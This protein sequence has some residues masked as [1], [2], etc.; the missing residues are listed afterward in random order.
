MFSGALILV[1]NLVVV[2][3]IAE[4]LAPEAPLA[5][6]LSIWLTALYYPLIYWT[7]RGMEVGLVTLTVSMS[8]LLAL[9]L[10]DRVRRQD[11]AALAALMVAG[12]LTRPDVVVPCAVIADLSADRCPCSRRVVAIVLLGA[13]VG[14]LTTPPSDDT[15]PL[16]NT[17]YLVQRCARRPFVSGPDR[18]AVFDLLHLIVL[19]VL[20]AVAWSLARRAGAATAPNLLAALFAV[21]CA[22][23]VY[24]GGDAWTTCSTPIDTSPRRC[25]AFILTATARDD[26]AVEAARALPLLQVSL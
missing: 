15:A 5:A 7:L 19:V 24:V 14:T 12:I 3:K 20:S 10:R 17:Y 9:R 2:R 6:S 23:S 25:P 22:Y 13:I 16:P 1:A 26:L 21:L 18:F 4:R 8:V 11:L